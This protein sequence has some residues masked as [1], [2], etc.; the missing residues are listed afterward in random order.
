MG[1]PEQ[2]IRGNVKLEPSKE[3]PRMPSSDNAVT[4]LPSSTKQGSTPP[5]NDIK[6]DKK[7]NKSHD[8][9]S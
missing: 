3:P 1:V 5:S 2:V 8:N 6:D 9:K 7:E 4:Y